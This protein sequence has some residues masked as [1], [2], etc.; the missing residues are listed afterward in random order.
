MQRISTF[1]SARDAISHGGEIQISTVRWEARTATH[2]SSA[3]GTYVRVRAKDSS[4]G[5]SPE[6]L[7]RIFDSLFTTKGEQGTGFWACRRYAHP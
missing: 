4:H 6:T 7:K 1:V 2:T 5:M 3:L